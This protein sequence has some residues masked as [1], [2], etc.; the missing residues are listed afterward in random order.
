MAIRIP[1]PPASFHS[2]LRLLQVRFTRGL[3]FKEVEKEREKCR[4]D[5]IPSHLPFCN[6][7]EGEE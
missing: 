5:M 6:R 4:Q 7:L 2:G 1:P 3:N